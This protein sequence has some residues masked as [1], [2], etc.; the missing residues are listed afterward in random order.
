MGRNVNEAPAGR[1]LHLAFLVRSFGFP[2]GWAA[3][4]RLRL[5]G[6]AMAAENVDVSVLVTRVSERPGEIRNRAVRGAADGIG[7]LYTPGST[8]RS[9]SFVRR[10][11]SEARGYA[12]AIM[13]LAR[14]RRAGRLDCVYLAALPETWRPSVWLLLRWLRRRGIPVIVELNEIPGEAAWLPRR[15]SRHFS[16]LD[17]ASGVVAIS[18]WLAGWSAAEAARIGRRVRVIEVPI[19]VDVDE[20]AVRPCPQGRPSFLYSASSDYGFAV[21]FILKAMRV[22]WQAHPDCELVVTGMRP[23][24]VADVVRREGVTGSGDRVRA[25]GYVERERLVELYASSSALLIPLFDN[26]RS[27]ARFP[28]KIGEYLAA[29]RPVVTTAVGEIERFFHDRESAYISPPEDPAAFAGGLLEII[30]DP[31]HAARVGAAGRRLAET[32]F[33]YRGH[34]PALRAFLD[35]LCEPEAAPA[36]HPRRADEVRRP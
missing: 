25:V 2:H 23:D 6:L 29:G 26:L 16:H 11:L 27:Q 5:L 15:L 19:V 10:R 34:G 14:R 30:D 18:S 32:R 7:F 12:G 28:T 22:V 35:A 21:A 1:R 36:Q 24:I 33:E 20:G 8:S 13:E 4:N 31:G 9:G 17:S 3:T